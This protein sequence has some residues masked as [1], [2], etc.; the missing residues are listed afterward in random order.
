MRLQSLVVSLVLCGVAGSA[1]AAAL[2]PTPTSHDFMNVSVSGGA[3]APFVFTLEAD[4]NLTVSAFGTTGACSEFTITPPAL[5]VDMANNDTI[6]VSVTYNPSNRI[7]DTCTITPT[8]SGGDTATAFT[9]TGD[10][11]APVMQIN[12]A[13]LTFADQRWN[14]GTP[15]TLNI[16]IT[17][18]GDESIAAANVVVGLTTGTHFTVGTLTGFPIANGQTA[19]IPITFDPQ[20]FGAKTDTATI[21]LTNDAPTDPDDTVALSGDGIQSTQTFS[22]ASLNVGTFDIGANG[23]NTISI[24]NSGEATLNLTSV[25][26]I[27]TNASDFSFTDHAC[28]NQGPC[29]PNPA[30]PIAMG[31]TDPFVI[32]CT[33]SATG[34]RTATLEVTSNDP[35]G[36]RTATLTCTG[37]SPE[38]TVTPTSLAY[39]TV[40]V[41]Q[42]VP[43]NFTISN[44]NAPN[45]S[46]LDYNVTEAVT[47]FTIA[48]APSCMG[49]LAP[50]ASATVTVTFS[51]SAT[52]L[53][54]GD[55]TV[56]TNDISEPTTLVAVSGTGGESNMS[57]AVPP[58]FG[59]VP[60]ALAGGSVQNVT[61]TNNGTVSLNTTT[62][63]IAG[64]AAFSFA[65][66]SG[67]CTM[68]TICSSAQRVVTAAANGGTAV[69][70]IRCDPT[71]AGSKMA[72]LTIESDDPMPIGGTVV[73]LSCTGTVSAMA[74]TPPSL[75]FGNQRINTNSTSQT[76][77][78]SNVSGLAALNY[79]VTTPAGGQFTTSI[80]ALVC[81]PTCANQ[82]VAAGGMA[83]ITVV[84]RPTTVGLKNGVV[85]ID[86]LDNFVSDANVAV[87]GTGVE[88]TATITTPTTLAFGNVLI[89]QTSTQQAITIVN[90]GTQDLT[91]NS[92]THIEGQA[93]EDNFDVIGALGMSTITAGGGMQTW[94]VVCDPEVRGNKTG[95]VT[96]SN[97]STNAPAIVV[98]LTC[99]AQE[100]LLVVSAAAVPIV[101]G[102]IDFGPVRLNNSAMTTVTLTNAGNID[103]NVTS[104]TISPTTEGFSNTVLTNT[105]VPANSAV[106]RTFVVTFAPTLDAQGMATLSIVTDWNDATITLRGDGEPTGFSCTPNPAVLGDVQWDGTLAQTITLRNTGTARVDVLSVN[107][108]SGDTGEFA[109]I[110]A[111]TGAGGLNAGLMRQFN[112]TAQPT[113]A[114]LGLRS[115]VLR[116]T[117]DLPPGMGQTCDIPVSYTSVGPA[118]TL[119]PGMLIDFGGVDVDAGPAMI[120]LQVANSG[121]GRMDI[122]NTTALVP[123]FSR[124]NFVGTQILQQQSQSLTIMFDPSM[125]RD[126]ANPEVQTFTIQT[127]GLYMGGTQQPASIL[128]TVRGFGIDRHIGVTDVVFPP[129]YRNPT[130]AQ[131]PTTT[132]GAA[133]N[134][135][136]A[137]RVCNTGGAMLNVTMIDDPDDNFDLAST[138]PLLVNGGTP[139]A[140]TCTEVAVAFRPTSYGTFMG[141][142]TI[143]N[144]DNAQPMA[145]VRLTGDGIAR[146]VEMM[147]NTSPAATIAIGAPV[148]LSEILGGTGLV[149]RNMS[150][151]ETFDAVVSSSSLT[152]GVTATLVGDD[153]TL[154]G[155]ETRE[156]DVELIGTAPGA[157]EVVVEVH[158]DGD[159]E[160]H[161]TLNIPLEV[162]RVDVEGGGCDGGGG[163]AAAGTALAL[164]GLAGGLLSRR[165]RRA[166]GAA[167]TLLV[168]GLAAGLAP[169][170]ADVSRN[171]DVGTAPTSTS[172]E[173]GLFDVDTPDVA[174]KGSWALGFAVQYETNPMVARWT[175]SAM[176]DHELGLITTR[177]AFAIGLGYALTDRLELSARLP[178]YSQASEARTMDAPF[179]V[180]GA[181]GFALGDV[182]VRAKAQV[183]EGNVGFAG[184]LDVTAPTR[185][186]GQF[187]GTDLPTAHVQ[188]L[189][190]IRAGRRLSLALNGGF[191]ARQSTQFMLVEQG[192]ELTYG[193]ALA[194]RV[195]DKVAVVG[196]ASGA[197][198]VVGAEG[199]VSPTEVTIGLRVRAS[200][201]AT[202]GLGGGSGFGRGIGVPDMRGF[203]TISIA[204]GAS[205][206]EPVRIVVPPPPRDTRDDDGD[207]VANADD[208]CRTDAEDADGFKDEDG[209]P[210]ADNDEDG[211]LDGDDKC[212][213]E[214][215]DKDGFQDEDGCVDRDNDTDGIDDVD[216]KCPAEPED[217]D[218][219]NDN[220]GCDEP[221][222]DNDGVPDVLDQC[223]LEPETINGNDD[224]DGCP[225]KGDAGVMLMTDRIEVLEPIVF[226]G[227]TAKLKPSS[228]RVLAQVGATLRA[229]RGVKRVRVTVHVH[230]RGP[231]DD[232]LSEKRADEIRKWLIQWG[233]EPERVEAKGI[234]SKRPLVAKT[235][236]GAEE[237]NDRVEF[238]I[239]ERN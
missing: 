83:S 226:A 239:L 104:V 191:L 70:P 29:V 177:T 174:D 155:N 100:G 178:M 172:T 111:G 125:E 238:I 116:I 130:D 221:D 63:T 156:L 123:P 13:T 180:E 97:N 50:G 82:V 199:K 94:N 87:S 162:V 147:P 146:P 157:V 190:G 56:T 59:N 64:D 132:C 176:A 127:D 231:G 141:T 197:L 189:L 228:N 20:S 217:K 145:L 24:G 170:R 67:G 152:A 181:S 134:E 79:S 236:R 43:Q 219:F 48:C 105:V 182:G 214:P 126:A 68:G 150:G 74:V 167:L 4:G 27:G 35:G 58:A 202:V 121:S 47:D 115:A 31:A 218:G 196:E 2:T 36:P 5:P 18:N 210:D 22:T 186:D 169:A 204:P 166:V 96:I 161:S 131:V 179:G 9:V 165:R 122:T 200:R 71:S 106:S 235:K 21:S 37:T 193:A 89:N 171:I 194:L 138:A 207:L 30:G 46:S 160:A 233:V 175:D 80:G 158:L 99:T 151:T 73:N 45:T 113:D 10:G 1:W 203:V 212:A 140:P 144:N 90:N 38:V 91:I 119:T 61:I 208:A 227:A 184:A 143:M 211:M 117:T 33:P 84:F 102:V 78:V 72:T 232:Q 26:I 98:S 205:P 17:N 49:T 51:P 216:D 16:T 110:P 206:V 223:A 153:G 39:G 11:I 92:V 164:L 220:D 209:C 192:S 137:L 69:I 148:R 213:L 81:N 101:A 62:M 133:G 215:E 198:G 60:V 195:L 234:G 93:G 154:A 86:D 229:E 188:A 107:W 185:S 7:A 237:I 65:F 173:P 34:T 40:R 42:S 44:S 23:T 225:D 25:R 201:S 142:V 75:S 222:N 41:G 85:V 108:L 8:V 149:L 163:G 139:A 88:P 120:T 54:T 14:G 3:T 114:M 19:N 66:A 135:A 57:S 95:S 52:V 112:I 159:P 183:V 15:Q 6:T 76:I 136:C 230:P 28:S 77:T 224:E 53:R 168:V 12:E 129:T 124:T 187:T 109:A 32:R 55:I 103:L 118:V 128:V